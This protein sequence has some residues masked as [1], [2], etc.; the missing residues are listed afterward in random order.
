MIRTRI[1]HVTLAFCYREGVGA[2][3]ALCQICA[4]LQRTLAHSSALQRTTPSGTSL[5]TVSIYAHLH[6]LWPRSENPGV[7]GSIPSQPTILPAT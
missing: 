2:R 7:G 4:Q 5:S 6:E 1:G 3:P